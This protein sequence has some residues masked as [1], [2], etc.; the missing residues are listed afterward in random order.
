MKI[1]ILDKDTLGLDIDLSP[2]R[3]IGSRYFT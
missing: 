2:L 1:S 3:D